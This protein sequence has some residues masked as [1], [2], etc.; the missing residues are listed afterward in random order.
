VIK[1]ASQISGEN[2]NFSLNVETSG[3]PIGKKLK[4][5]PHFFTVNTRINFKWIRDLKVEKKKKKRNH[6]SARLKMGELLS[7]LSIQKGFLIGK[8][9]I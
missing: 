7:N 9:Q 4:W 5:Y 1:A 8:I 6:L 2:M 3:Q